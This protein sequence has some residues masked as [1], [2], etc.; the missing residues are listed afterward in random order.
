MTL[1]ADAEP[2]L[3]GRRVL[4]AAEGKTTTSGGASAENLSAHRDRPTRIDSVSID[5]SGASVRG[6]AEHRSHAQITFDEFPV[7]VHDSEV[8]DK[9]CRLARKHDPRPKGL[10]WVLLKDRDKR[11]A[12][13]YTELGGLLARMTTTRAARVRRYRVRLS[14]ILSRKQSNVMYLPLNRCGRNVRRCE[15]GPNKALADVVRCHLR[16]ILAWMS[17]RHANG[18]R[19]VINGLFQ[20]AAR[21]GRGYGRL[22]MIRIANFLIDDKLDFS[23]I[24]PYVAA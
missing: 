6:V 21:R 12:A 8:I 23:P 14:E 5:M 24:G 19:D 4:F 7:I 13:Q 20:A 2:D 16:S 18:V 10:R 15:V 11:T 3:A 9:L 17:S 22:R 1:L